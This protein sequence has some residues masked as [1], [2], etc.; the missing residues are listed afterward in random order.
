LIDAYR[1][2][3]SLKERQMMLAKLRNDQ[4]TQALGGALSKAIYSFYCEG[5][6]DDDDNDGK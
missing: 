2:L 4:S 3:S 5:L 1:A 6:F